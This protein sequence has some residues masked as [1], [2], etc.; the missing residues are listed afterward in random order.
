M[1]SGLTNA[2]LDQQAL[3]HD[4]R[5]GERVLD[6]V[7]VFLGRFV[8][9]PSEHAHVAHTL[10]I[11]HTHLMEVWDSTPRLA[12][13]SAEPASGKT[14][15]LEVTELLVPHPVQTVN[16]S[17]A[18]LFRK[19]G[20]EDGATILFDEIDTIFGAKA[21]DH[22]DIRGLLNAGHRR[23]ATTGRCVVRGRTV[24]TEEL[25]AYAAVALAGL[26]WL[27]DT[28]LSR[29]VVIRMRRRS[30][31]E[32]IEPYRRRLQEHIGWTLRDRIASWAEG[33]ASA[34][35][36]PSLPEQIT[37]RNADL[38]EPLVAVADVVGGDW[39][40]R[41]RVA[42]VALVAEGREVEPS[43]GVK[44][45]VDLKQVFGDTRE[46]PSKAI[47]DSLQS[48]PESPWSDLRGKPLDQRGLAYHLRQYG[49]RSKTIRMG[50]ATPKGYL[51]GDFE[52]VWSR[53][54]PS[55]ARSATSA[56][57]AAAPSEW[58]EIS[59]DAAVGAS[60]ASTPVAD[61]ADVLDV[62]AQAGA[63]R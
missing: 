13:L 37:D 39:P 20:N 63:G 14:R 15:A 55:P 11:V 51:R 26:G 42:A 32:R 45:L 49:I 5:A 33:V 57:S 8:A 31:A 21:K 30:S 18:Y 47:L 23:G 24:V 19:V 54:L 7:Y 56:T 58:A 6:A 46:L 3:E 36:W 35:K 52:D 28:L 62:R 41:A 29:S 53:Y 25:P 60:R 4:E 43:L 16:V 50:D 40:S 61:V 22:E 34:I 10:W 17:P 2:Q 12:F 48:L 38:W 27:P 44:L 1:S 59:A 9:Y